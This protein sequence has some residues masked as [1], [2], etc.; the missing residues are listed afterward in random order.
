MLT[1]APAPQR[2]SNPFRN[3]SISSVLAEIADDVKREI[4][5]KAAKKAAKKPKTRANEK[6]NVFKSD[7]TA[8]VIEGRS[9]STNQYILEDAPAP[10]RLRGCVNTPNDNY[11]RGMTPLARLSQT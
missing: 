8:L 3:I 6:E 10:R 4:D 2:V 11:A 7:R 5:E 1:N 9:R